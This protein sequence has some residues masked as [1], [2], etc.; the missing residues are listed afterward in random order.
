M[1]AKKLSGIGQRRVSA[2]SDGSPEYAAKRADLIAAA[3]K[4]FRQKGYAKATLNDVAKEFGTDR[5][6]LY[7][8]VSSK[9]ELL[10]ACVKGLTAENLRRAEAIVASNSSPREC[11]KALIV[12]NI[13]SQVE[14]YPYMYV[15]VQEIMGHVTSLDE[16][17]ARDMVAITRGI[18]QCF[19][20][21]IE[22]GKEAGEFKAELSTTLIANAVFGMTQWTHRWWAPPQSRYTA[23]DVSDAFIEVLLDG[24]TA[25]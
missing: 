3:A 23:T 25:R 12:M 7:Y 17:W 2:L 18:E 20:R 21:T 6:S 16:P 8:Y 11:L 22:A 9:E 19:I 4:V 24:I 15:Y 10:Q 14:H 1:V 13:E 5:A